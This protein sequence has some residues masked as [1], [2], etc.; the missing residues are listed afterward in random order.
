MFL[1]TASVFDIEP[2]VRGRAVYLRP[3]IVPDYLAWASLRSESRAFLARWEPLWPEDDLTRP[4]F[5]RRIRRYHRDMREDQSYPFLVFRQEDHVLVG[6]L[7]L[8][9]VRRGVAQA[10]SLGYWVGVPFARHG[11][12]SDAVEAVLQFAFGTLRLHRVEAACLPYN[13]PSI[14]LLEKVGFQREG[15]ARRYLC[16]NGAW[17]DHLLFAV[18]SDDP[19]C[20]RGAAAE[21]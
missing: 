10:C 9:Y 2:T 17:Q 7:S 20:G 21:W 14:G 13:A 19:L 11:Y 1:R 6:G 8:S 16:I 4:A 5:R 15:Y 18:L 12:M 3:P